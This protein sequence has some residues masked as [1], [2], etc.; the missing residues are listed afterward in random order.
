MSR[1][2][3]R[4]APE[5]PWRITTTN[6]ATS[7]RVVSTQSD[8]P[9]A[10]RGGAVAML[11]LLASYIPFAL[12]IGSTCADHGAALAAWAGCF[13]IF[14]GSAHLAA[15]RTLDQ[16][17][18]LAAILTGLLVNARLLVYSTSLAS[19]WSGQ[20]RWFRVAAAGLII[21]PTWA[22][23][24]RHAGECTDLRHQ[25]RY[26]LSAGVTLGAGWSGAMALGALMGTRLDWLDL[27]IFIPLCL[28]GLVGADLRIFSSVDS[29]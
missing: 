22:A 28:L 26:F 19:R 15:V 16:A 7:T 6:A 23:A 20:P 29:R 18:P 27:Q 24:E 9:S 5:R 14:G 17:G 2:G 3:R 25:R 8:V 10:V 13:L 11:P 1:D 21:D 4:K 12:V